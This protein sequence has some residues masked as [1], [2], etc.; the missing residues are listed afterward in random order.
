MA[1][2]T[3]EELEM[4]LIKTRLQY[5]FRS[6]LGAAVR[7]VVEIGV[8]LN[9]CIENLFRRIS[10]YKYH[11]NIYTNEE[12]L[13][14]RPKRYG[15]NIEKVKIKH[16]K[17]IKAYA[18]I[19]ILEE[20]LKYQGH[21]RDWGVEVL[22]EEVIYELDGIVYTILETIKDNPLYFKEK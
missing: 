6:K 21:I 19:Y 9:H 18:E 3:R 16:E 11:I 22:P 7:D 5:R 1:E 20:F 12:E 14:V 10:D 4:E 13:K 2:K 17:D 15:Q 8:D